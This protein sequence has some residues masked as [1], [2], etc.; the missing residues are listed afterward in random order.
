MS[1][2][3][4]KKAYF[5]LFACVVYAFFGRPTPDSFG[6][7]EA[8]ISLCLLCGIGFHALNQ[9]FKER[10]S[11]KWRLFGFGLFVYGFTVPVVMGIFSGYGYQAILRDII[12]FLFLLLPIFLRPL[13]H[14]KHDYF[15]VL[16]AGV[17]IIGLVFSVRSL[18]W[19]KEAFLYLENMPTVLFA[20][21]FLLGLGLH[22]AVF[23]KIDVFYICRPIAL[24]ALSVI[25]F[26]VIVLSLQRASVAAAILYVALLCLFFMSRKPYRILGS[27]ILGLIVLW[28]F[29][30]EIHMMLLPLL[31]KTRDVGLNMR[32]QEFTA[33]WAIVSD[34]I[35][36]FLFGIGW[37]G[38]FSSPAVGGVRVNF[39]H[40]FFSSM[41]LKAGLFGVLFSFIYSAGLVKLLSKVV[42]NNPVL[43]LAL[44]APVLID[45]TLYASYKSLDFGL[46]LALIPLSYSVFSEDEYHQ[47][48]E[49]I[50]N[51][52]K[53]AYST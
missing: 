2:F 19:N 21:L 7:T 36:H 18:F 50:T 3:T 30:A 46:V 15:Y 8:L 24:S 33:V 40:S 25:P 13:K 20:G 34:N 6:F 45:L 26:L 27:S 37:G 4:P 35:L 52:T 39:T 43:G 11:S 44:S 49:S 16:L 48:S 41:L 17:L 14:E 53:I 5:L 9:I 42:W 32:P 23:R 10:F 1:V 28:L 29:W 51:N 31:E 12:P 38:D 22:S 47:E